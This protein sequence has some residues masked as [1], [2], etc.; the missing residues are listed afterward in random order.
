MKEKPEPDAEGR[1]VK[2]HVLIPVKSL[3]LLQEGGEVTGGFA[4][5]I[6]TGDAR[7]NVSPINRQKHDIRW[8][9]DKLP[10]MLEKTI[11]FNVDVVM[12]PGRNQISVGVMD[13]RSQQMG[14][15]KTTM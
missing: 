10:E 1:R 3:K 14:F 7:G 6:S 9:A 15:A 11:G 2:L 8:P 4:V 13:Q 12:K 5:Y